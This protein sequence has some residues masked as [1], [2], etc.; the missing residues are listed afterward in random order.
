MTHRLE[1]RNDSRW[2]YALGC[3][4]VALLSV[5]LIGTG[6]AGMRILGGLLLLTACVSAI[7]LAYDAA[8]VAVSLALGLSVTSLILIALAL[9]VVHFLNLNAVWITLAIAILTILTA[10]GSAWR[11]GA[12]VGLRL[13]AWRSAFVGVV[14]GMAILATSAVFA[15]RY[16]ADSAAADADRALSTAVWAYES[17]GQLHVGAAAPPGQGSIALEV[18]VTSGKRLVASW[19]QVHIAS[20]RS[21]EGRPLTLRGTTDMKVTVRSNGKIIAVVPVRLHALPLAFEAGCGTDMTVNFA[22]PVET[23]SR[24]NSVGL[25]EYLRSL[26]LV[27]Y[28]PA[29]DGWQYM[30]TR[31]NRRALH[32]T[33]GSCAI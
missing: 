9:A 4:F 17:G 6:L 3:S 31:W 11:G 20:D 16:S 33:L 14:V 13:T 2:K 12:P 19:N 25:R 15:V 26:K 24:R 18:D 5:V 21:W 10:C 29:V 1:L 7:W 28:F 23:D 27:N 30:W 8:F 22:S 32:R